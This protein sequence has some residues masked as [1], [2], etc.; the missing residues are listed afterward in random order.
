MARV[1]DYVSFTFT[2]NNRTKTQNSFG[3]TNEEA[4]TH[5][6]TKKSVMV[7]L[8]IRRHHLPYVCMCFYSNV[9]FFVQKSIRF[10]C[11]CLSHFY[12]RLTY[13]SASISSLHIYICCW[14]VFD[15]FSSAIFHYDEC[16]FHLKL[17]IKKNPSH[18]RSEH[19]LNFGISD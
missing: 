14:F 7:C 8:L 6:R 13:I 17:K 4:R 18:W 12:T 1:H 11:L 3:Q 19:H 16:F 9:F 2:H 5:Q 10:C 15:F